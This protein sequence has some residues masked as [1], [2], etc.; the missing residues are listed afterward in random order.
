DK[1]DYF[2]EKFKK[3]VPSTISVFKTAQGDYDIKNHEKVLKNQL[4][5]N[6]QK[7]IELYSDNDEFKLRLGVLYRE[8][9]KYDKA[10]EIFNMLLEKNSENKQKIVIEIIYTL[11]DKGD[12]KQ[13]LQMLKDEKIQNAELE[14]FLN[15]RIF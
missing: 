13:A 1:F 15:E 6:L 11:K 8:S 4:I 7:K 14:R 5:Q 10:L 9:K 3:L 12:Y 2:F